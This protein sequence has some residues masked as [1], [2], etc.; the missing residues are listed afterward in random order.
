MEFEN[1]ETYNISELS[2]VSIQN[3]IGGFALAAE[4]VFKNPPLAI[5]HCGFYNDKFYITIKIRFIKR[6]R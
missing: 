3:L 4:E 6:S 1:F 5:I 2:W